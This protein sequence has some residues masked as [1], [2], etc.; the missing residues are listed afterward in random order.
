MNYRTKNGPKAGE[1]SSTIKTYQHIGDQDGKIS[2]TTPLPLT[3]AQNMTENPQNPIFT[4]VSNEAPVRLPPSIPELYN[5]GSI[6]TL[7]SPM[8]STTTQ[9]SY[10]PW[11]GTSL[12]TISTLGTQSSQGAIELAQGTMESIKNLSIG[13]DWQGGFQKWLKHQERIEQQ[14]LR[15]VE[16]QHLSQSNGKWNHSSELPTVFSRTILSP[17]KELEF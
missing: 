15:E 14:Q 1:M 16:A 8:T 17:F 6:E 4:E 5:P 7:T 3:T 2:L 12:A 10:C 11:G 13:S 9:I